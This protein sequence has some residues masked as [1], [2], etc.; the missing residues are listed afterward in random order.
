MTALRF[1]ESCPDIKPTIDSI[2]HDT[3]TLSPRSTTPPNS[4][5]SLNSPGSRPATP[6]VPP[7]VARGQRPRPQVTLSYCQSVDGGVAVAGG[8]ASYLAD[9]L[10]SC[11]DA[12]LTGEV[13]DHD[14]SVF[15]RIIVLDEH[16]SRMSLEGPDLSK[17]WIVS[18]AVE[19]ETHLQTKCARIIT[20]TSMSL[21]DILQALLEAGIRKLAIEGCLAVRF[22]ETAMFDK[23][24]VTIVPTFSEQTSTRVVVKKPRLTNTHFEVLGDNV[25][26]T[27]EPDFEI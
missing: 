26:L 22:L 16:V 21:E 19:G 14:L 11:H 5:N 12:V 4:F 3:F 25:I 7:Y 9:R 6:K 2:V 20:P 8:E 23:L 1:T 18:Q 10:R 17:V 13:L 15:N 27:A 24:V